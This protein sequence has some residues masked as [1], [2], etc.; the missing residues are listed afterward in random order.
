MILPTRKQVSHTVRRADEAKLREIFNRYASVE[1]AGEKYMTHEDFILKYLKLFPD[2]NYNKK[3]AHLLGGILDTSKDGFVSLISLF[4]TSSYHISFIRLISFVE[5]NA[6][7]AVLCQPDALYRTAFQVRQ[8]ELL[9]YNDIN[10]SDSC[11]IQMALVLLLMTNLKTSSNKRLCMRR[12]RS[13]SKDSSCSYILE[14]TGNEL[15]LFQ[16]F[17]KF[18]TTFTKNMQFRLSSE[19]I[20]QNQEPYQQ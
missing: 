18:F 11:S 2:E 14:K 10:F 1:K 12:Y 4:V 19:W 6:F 13:I 7:E 15:S 9:D 17:L 16:N 3:T 20:R 8:F 5:F